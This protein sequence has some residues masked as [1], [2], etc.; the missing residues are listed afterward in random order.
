MM[1]EQALTE[2]IAIKALQD[3]FREKPFLFFGS[4]L[5]CALDSRFG[6]DA[7]TETLF[8]NIKIYSL[9]YE[10][11]EEWAKVEI[12][13]QNG[14][15]L[16]SA[17]NDVKDHDLLDIIADIAGSFMVPLDRE[18]SYRIANNQVKWPA[19]HFL[20]KLVDTLP[21]G[22]RILHAMTPNYDMLFEYACDSAGIVYSNGFIGGI[23]KKLDWDAVDRSLLLPEN[24]KKHRRFKKIFRYCKHVRLYKVHG[25]LNYFFHRNSVIE[26]DAWMWEPPNYAQRVI[27][28]PGLSKYEKLQYYRQELLKFADKAIEK[29]SNFLFIGYGFNDKHIEEY[30]KRKLITQS[31]KGLIITRDCNPRIESLLSNSSNL[32][33]V[34]KSQ[35]EKSD[36]TSIYNKQYSNWLSISDKRL[37]DVREFT[38]HVLGG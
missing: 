26:N 20:M 30:I 9:N 37:W 13:L 1:L 2:E 36:F 15:D 3:F 21:E 6:M 11:K 25:S 33:L 19:T 8:D 35:D 16:E 12:L 24:V 23:E 10:Q 17:L 34:C 32:W 29:S 27:I 4:G 14:H 28:T 22:D 38:N 31:C 7:L 5:S 18:Y